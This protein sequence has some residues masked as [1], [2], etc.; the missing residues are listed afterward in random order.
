MEK[1]D[2]TRCP[3]SAVARHSPNGHE[4]QKQQPT[5]ILGSL[6]NISVTV[7]TQKGTAGDPPVTAKKGSEDGR[8]GYADATT[9]QQVVNDSLVLH[10]DLRDDTGTGSSSFSIGEADPRM[11]VACVLQGRCASS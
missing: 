9:K 1:K 8:Q 7:E 10:L 2:E 4:S 11:F 3:T 5:Q 6:H